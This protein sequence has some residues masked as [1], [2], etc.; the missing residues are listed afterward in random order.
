MTHP[1]R[2]IIALMAFAATAAS[3]ADKPAPAAP[4]PTHEDISFGSHPHQLIDIYLP[5]KGDE[6]FPAVLWFGG[7][8]KAAKHPANLGFFESKGIAVIA[9]QVRT[10]EDATVAKDPEPASYVQGDAVR[11]VQFVRHNAAK[12]NLDPKHIAVGGGSQGAQ[13]ALFVGCSRDH[14]NT[15]S[16]DPVERESSL[17][18]CVAAYRCQP[19]F[20]PVRMQEWVPG[21]KWVRPPSAARLTIR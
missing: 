9:V 5:K 10:M 12:W 18:T 6:P 8:W 19:T 16:A 15:A 4:V 3:A 7:I 20:D 21:V 14:A 17:V 11:A 13:P 1:I 2:T